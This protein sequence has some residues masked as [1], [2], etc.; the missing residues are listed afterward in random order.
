MR[1]KATLIVLATISLVA[2]EASTG[3]AE[4]ARV[5][6]CPPKHHVHV[7]V[8]DR[9]AVVY[10][11]P[12]TTESGAPS[13]Y[14]EIFGCVR[15]LGRS[16]LLGSP[17]SSGGSPSGTGGT[18]K[19]RL[20][21]T[22]VA[23]ESYGYAPLFQ[24]EGASIQHEIIVRNLRNGRTLHRLPTGTGNSAKERED[25]DVGIGGATTLVVNSAGAVAWVVSVYTE[26]LGAR[27]AA[28]HRE[29]SE[30]QLHVADSTG[31]RVL[32]EGT[33]TTSLSL[34]LKGSVL[35]WEVA[36]KR[37]YATLH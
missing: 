33:T 27:E 10:K 15:S 20:S 12:G 21:G 24:P 8:A 7:I 18:A 5:P 2:L 29:I 34:R 3:A 22:V 30:Y 32:S 36:G 28:E 23:F 6:S 14:T 11:G 37:Y 26:A 16:Y 19:Y 31:T 25:G 17:P 13:E 9:L 4:G 1:S 35:S